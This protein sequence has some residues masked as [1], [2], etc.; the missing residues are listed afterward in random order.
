MNRPRNSLL[1]ASLALAAGLAL[2]AAASGAALW[3][4]ALAQA[5]AAP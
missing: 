3:A 5:E 4:R 2:A 1:F